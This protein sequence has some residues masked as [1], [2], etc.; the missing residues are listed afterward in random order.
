MYKN[1][2]NKKIYK[3]STNKIYKNFDNKKILQK[4]DENQKLRNKIYFTR[5]NLTVLTVMDR[6]FKNVS[7][8]PKQNLLKDL[9]L[10]C[11]IIDWVF[12]SSILILIPIDSVIPNEYTSA[13]IKNIILYT[14]LYFLYSTRR[15]VC[16]LIV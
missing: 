10:Y 12:I 16:F 5:N 3:S 11:L 2:D 8:K 13:I 1:F 7:R 6:S 9:W 4:F 14:I 15:H